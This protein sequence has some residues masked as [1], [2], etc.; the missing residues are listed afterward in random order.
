MNFVCDK[1][2]S[3]PFKNGDKTFTLGGDIT[4]YK[5]DEVSAPLIVRDPNIVALLLD[6][7][8]K[9]FNEF[10][11][12]FEDLKGSIELTE[13]DHGKHFEVVIPNS[14]GKIFDLIEKL[15]IALVFAHSSVEA[16]INNLIP[17][18]YT[19]E[20]EQKKNGAKAFLTVDKDW[21]E[22]NINLSEKIKDII[23]KIYNLQQKIESESFW[24]CFE[25]LLELRNAIV[26]PKTNLRNKGNPTQINFIAKIFSISVSMDI[27]SSSR[28]LIN[29]FSKHIQEGNHNVSISPHIPIEFRED[30]TTLENYLKF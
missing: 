8:E 1:R 5:K 14:E 10:K 6:I 29:F 19:L 3:V 11:N 16:F 9:S 25:H 26:H 17:K 13:N 27:I 18:D 28:N 22:R 7:S 24:E 12:K 15:F 23:P 21:I 20:I 30:C 2:C 4:V